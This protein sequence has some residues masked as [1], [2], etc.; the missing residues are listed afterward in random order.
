LSV[1]SPRDLQSEYIELKNESFSGWPATT[2]LA[3]ALLGV[4]VADNNANIIMARVRM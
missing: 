4:A 3:G 1:D 2:D